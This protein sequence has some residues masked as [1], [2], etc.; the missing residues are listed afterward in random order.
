MF[1]K[2]G[3]R[4]DRIITRLVDMKRMVMKK[5][6]WV[7]VIA[8]VISIFGLYWINAGK[9]ALKTTGEV[10]GREEVINYTLPPGLIFSIWGVIYLGFLVYA[11]IGLNQ[12]AAAD[13]QMNKTAYPVAGSILLNL[14]WTVVVGLELW[15]WAYP[16][17]WIMLVLALMILFRWDLNRR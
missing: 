15:V 7:V 2:P 8:T 17:Q 11:F 9:T 6:Q 13:P 14:L 5:K 16:L 3:C 4:F 12:N 1:V 10:A